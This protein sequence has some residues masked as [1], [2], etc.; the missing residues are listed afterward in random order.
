MKA[1]FLW[2]KSS[3]SIRL[4][5]YCQKG[6]REALFE[7]V[8]LLAEGDAPGA[9]DGGGGSSFTRSCLAEEERGEILHAVPEMPFVESDIAGED[10]VPEGEAELLHRLAPAHKTLGD[11]VIGTPDLIEESDEA[12]GVRF[13]ETFLA[14][15]RKEVSRE[16][17][18]DRLFALCELAL[19]EGVEIIDVAVKEVEEPGIFHGLAVLAGE[20]VDRAAPGAFEFLE[21]GSHTGHEQIVAFVRGLVQRAGN[22][23]ETRIDSSPIIAEGIGKYR[24]RHEGEEVAVAGRECRVSVHAIFVSFLFRKCKHYLYG[25]IVTKKGKA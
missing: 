14:K 15:R 21:T 13:A 4:S 2:P 6:P 23:G 10:I 22:T 12:Q 25:Y 20:G 16:R 19:D 18:R 7:G 1:P 3:D 8:F 24:L 17:D 5:G 11:E 9:A